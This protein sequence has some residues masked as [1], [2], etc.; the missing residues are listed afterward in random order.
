[1]IQT[2]ETSGGL[3]PASQIESKD[4]PSERSVVIVGGGL[5]GLA[6]A[7]EMAS[8]G[9]RVTLVEQNEHLGGKMNLLEDR[10]FA[11]D[12]GPTIITMPQVFR[13]I[14]ERAGRRPEDY[15]ELVDL[16]PQWRCFFEDGTVIDLRRDAEAFARELDQQF[17]AARPG[18]GYRAF[19]EY[20]RR[21][22]RLSER[23][24]FYKDLGAIGDLMKS[25][26]NDPGL[27]GDVLAMRMHST[28]GATIAKHIKEP[29][30]AQLCEHFLQYV[31]SSP[32]LAPAILSLIAA[33]QVDNGCWYPMG[34]PG[35]GGEPT[36]GGTR[37]IARTLAAVAA[38]LGVEVRTG[39][40]VAKIMSESGRATG[41]MLEGGRTILAD[42]VV[43][44]C[45]VQRTY[46]DLSS[47]PAADKAFDA[48]RS[49][50][51]PACSGLVLYLGLNRPYEHLA[52]HNFCFS[53]D[54][55]DEFHDIYKK[56]IPARDPT[57]YIAAPSR[58]D[59]G[60]A[61]EIDGQ[62][63]EAL[64]V[65]I[66]T[67][68]KREGQRWEG[69]GGML[70]RYRPVVIEKMKRMGMADIEE[71]IVCEHHL[72]PDGI[73]R[74]YNAEGGAIYGL[75]SHGKLAGGFKPRNRSKAIR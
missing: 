55:H 21:M 24:F 19:V 54:S 56:G 51:E 13:G 29:H 14:L 68:Y 61:P 50:Y 52:H 28:V 33:A 41:V 8:N 62:P 65:L 15:C 39:V 1:M 47:G 20:S 73:D 45:D 49:K 70:E 46:R 32:F 34:K 36:P 59:P 10:G 69:P 23:V 25:P 60:Q 75:A 63:G 44:N 6:A 58:T 11:F 53:G 38:E 67:A 66:H 40:R 7:V 22:F 42:A 5:A 18:A 3:H 4:H 37:M 48:V 31:G 27:L 74:M 26:P 17:P 16:D 9:L 57:L 30:L 2:N 35:P 64:Y 12:M 43:S 71:R 72:T